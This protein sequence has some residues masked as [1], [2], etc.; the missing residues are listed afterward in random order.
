MI[1]NA[2]HGSTDLHSF[3]RRA[4]KGAVVSVDESTDF[5]VHD[6]NGSGGF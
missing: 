2:F 4:C 5:H 1:A 6:R 3:T